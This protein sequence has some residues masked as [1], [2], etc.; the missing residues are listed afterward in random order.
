MKD[1]EIGQAVLRKRDIYGRD[2]GH[3]EL[4]IRLIP[5]QTNLVERNGY[6]SMCTFSEKI[7]DYYAL[8][9]KD[10]FQ[11][12]KL[13]GITEDSENAN[14]RLYSY[15]KK[16]AEKLLEELNAEYQR[17]TGFRK[18]YTLINEVESAELPAVSRRL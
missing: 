12:K 5:I 4:T 3:Y 18:G 2:L 9:F 16:N 17:I 6:Y 7:D 1:L 10:D 15:L 13:F 14:E 8:W 11:T